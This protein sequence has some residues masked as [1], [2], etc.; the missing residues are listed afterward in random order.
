MS[1]TNFSIQDHKSKNAGKYPSKYAAKPATRPEHIPATTQVGGKPVNVTYN[2]NQGGY[3]YMGASGSWMMYDTM[4]D[5]AIMS[6]L[7]NRNGYHVGPAV[8]QS[9]ERGC[10]SFGIIMLVVVGGII[11]AIV[12]GAIV[13]R[14]G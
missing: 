13:T 14:N 5:V 11:V 12:I 9:A 8:T 10:G 4:R 1:V 3:G 2:V 6:L 7:M